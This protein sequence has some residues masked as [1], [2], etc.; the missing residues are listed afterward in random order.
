M[1]LREAVASILHLLTVLCYGALSVFC[2][3]LPIHP[4]WRLHLIEWAEK[5]PE[6][7]YWGAVFFA[8]VTFF[9]LLGFYAV[10][11]GSYLRIQMQPHEAIVDAK[12]IEIALSEC[13][14][15]HFADSIYG[16][17]VSIA[18]K[19]RIEVAFDLA[20]QSVAQTEE[21]LRK[22]EEQFGLLLRNRFGYTLPFVAV[23]R[24]K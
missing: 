23:L 17:S 15:K 18:A 6:I 2:L 19:E 5:T 11:R 1:R 12:L 22:A 9:F 21:T 10:G 24:L 20:P 4:G 14:K 16:A 13:I 3:I 8:A 7:F